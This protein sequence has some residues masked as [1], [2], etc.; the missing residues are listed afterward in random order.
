M[1]SIMLI[2]QNVNNVRMVILL[3]FDVFEVCHVAEIQMIDVFRQVF[4]SKYLPIYHLYI[5]S[6]RQYLS[7]SFFKFLLK[8]ILVFSFLRIVS[9]SQWIYIALYIKLRFL[10]SSCNMRFIFLRVHPI[11][12]QQHIVYLK[13]VSY[14][15][16][17][18]NKY[19][20]KVESIIRSNKKFIGAFSITFSYLMTTEKV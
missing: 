19:P 16:G 5:F 3:T 4:T 8:Y 1:L 13:L 7:T 6:I 2:Q 12:S 18:K 17:N 15:Y 14:I 11:T 10:R 20:L 9:L